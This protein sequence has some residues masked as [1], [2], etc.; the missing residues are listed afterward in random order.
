MSSELIS[1]VA[2]EARAARGRKSSVL[3]L[4]AWWE[5]RPRVEGGVGPAPPRD[6]PKERREGVPSE[7]FY[8]LLF[9]PVGEPA[10]NGLRVAPDI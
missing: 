7:L 8:R 4:R 2:A 1:R 9:A 6:V 10:S 3:V 5:P